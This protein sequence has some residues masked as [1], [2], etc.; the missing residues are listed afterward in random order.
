MLKKPAHSSTGFTLI[1][2]MVVIVIIGLLATL[3][4]TS[5]ASALRRGRDAEIKGRLKELQVAQEQQRALYGSYTLVCPS[6]NPKITCPSAPTADAYCIQGDIERN[7][8]NCGG[9]S[10][11]TFTAISNGGYFC[12]AS[13]Q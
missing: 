10:G 6:D 3:G 8:G 9:C 4:L 1:E 12:V 2:L 7:D 5:Y 11:N 13:K